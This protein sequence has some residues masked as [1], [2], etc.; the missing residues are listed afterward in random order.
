MAKPVTRD[1]AERKKTQ[2]AEFLYRI[3]ELEI[4]PM[5]GVHSLTVSQRFVLLLIGQAAGA[6]LDRPTR[7]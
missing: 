5:P 2:A 3:G 7:T 4:A 1:L 6:A